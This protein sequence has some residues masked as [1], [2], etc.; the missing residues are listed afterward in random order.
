MSNA[1]IYVPGY[2]RHASRNKRLDLIDRVY[3]KPT[4][5]KVLSSYKSFNAMH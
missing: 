2:G 1:E 3:I 4:L 5:S